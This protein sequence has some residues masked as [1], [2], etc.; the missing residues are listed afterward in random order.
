MLRGRQRWSLM[1]SQSKPE[2]TA[3]SRRTFY[4]NHPSHEFDE[5]LGNN[6]SKA[7]ATILACRRAVNLRKGL[8]QPALGFAWDANTSVG[9]RKMEEGVGGG[10]FAQGDMDHHFTAVGEL[11]R[12]AHKMREHLAQTSGSPATHVGR[13]ACSR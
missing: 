11:D 4:A 3:C 5:A 13:S 12:I 9:H 10:F 8:E 1:Q 7:S 6:Q 2:C